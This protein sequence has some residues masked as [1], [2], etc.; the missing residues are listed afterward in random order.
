M[1]AFDGVGVNVGVLVGAGVRVDVTVGV[2]SEVGV[3]VGVSLGTKI[4]GTD[5]GVSGTP[6]AE[7]GLQLTKIQVRNKIKKRFRLILQTIENCQLFIINYFN[8][9]ILIL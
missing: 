6:H 1:L 5:V 7:A 2:C 9:G 8:I 3:T 4:V